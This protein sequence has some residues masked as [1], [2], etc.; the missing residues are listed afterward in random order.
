MGIR[1]F[2]PAMYLRLALL[3]SP[4][5]LLIACL[6]TNTKEES[7]HIKP[8][9]P[10]IILILA[11]DYG[12]M[13]S[14]A[15]AHKITG[16]DTTEMYYET[17]NIDKL[18]NE[19]TAFS[20]AYANQL[21]SPT[22][23][24]LLTGKY[25]GRLGFTTAMPPRNTY[26]NQSLSVPEGFYAHDVLE[27]KDP[28]DIE[29]A[30]VN[31][32]SNS[33]VPSGTEYDDGINELSLA[34][35]LENYHSAFIGKWHIGGFG[36]EGY[37]PADNGFEPL[38][39]Y[40]AG[41][42]AYFDWET[43]WND[44]SISRFPKIP[45]EELKMG[46]TGNRTNENY[47]TDDLTEQAVDFI[48]KRVGSEKPFF[49][50]FSHFAV[51]APYQAE[52]DDVAYF[53]EKSTQGWNGHQDAD[54]AGMVKSL[55]RSVGA[56]LRTLEKAD[57]E[58]N[59]L[60]I[61]MSD[62]GGIDASLT[63]DG[64][65]TDNSPFLGGKACLTEGGIR[66]PLIFRWK[67]K[68]K[69]GQWVDMPVDC[70]DIFPTILDFAGLDASGIV[71]EKSLDGQSLL[72]LLS[73]SAPNAKKYTKQT[74]YWHYPFNVIYNSPFEPFP[75]TPHS[76]VRDGDFKLIFDWY[77]RLRLF[78]IEK[79]PFEKSDLSESRPDLRDALFEKLMNWLTENID[80][81]YWPRLN[82]EYS[83]NQEVRE[84]AFQDMFTER[85]NA[86]SK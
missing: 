77:G 49:L 81:R 1:L 17:P 69:E 84:K 78:D 80:T 29:Q 14:Q 20:Q 76:A 33:A 39:W 53:K 57:M 56:I 52:S 18:L 2:F 75:L 59:T 85:L 44:T 79:D 60:V 45:Q 65:G 34:E 83:P 10:N 23:A 43:A 24:S 26:Y 9:K 48:K 71:S 32:T 28:I 15:Y 12:I 16:T 55:D 61:F 64:R 30:L 51:H 67:D 7:A 11:D 42:S 58:D 38:A 46:D 25:A 66:V 37:Q 4:A 82:P 8:Q 73:E 41:G 5:L 47:L 70:T 86:A 62:N 68:V 22:R 3:C 19:G 50:Y 63:P 6:P 54:Y 35:A 40:D 13:D 36:A 27:H 31:G 72:S 74:R 21:C